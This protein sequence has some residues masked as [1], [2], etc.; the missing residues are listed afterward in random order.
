M[1]DLVYQYNIFRNENKSLIRK[2]L[3]STTSTGGAYLIPQHLEKVI[4]N[5]LPRLR[6]ELAMVVSKYDALKIHTF[7]RLTGLPDADTAMGEGGVTP[8][9]NSTYAQASVELK[10]VRHKGAVT[11]FL[12]DASKT[13]ID[14][15]AAEMENH[16][17]SHVN[18]L[19]TY[20]LHGNKEANAYTFTGWDRFISTNRFQEAYGGRVPTNLDDL[21]EMI[22]INMSKQ[23]A[24]HRK[25]FLLSP[26]MISKLSRLLTNVRLNQGLTGNGLTTVE[27]PGGWRLAAYR[28]IPLIPTSQTRP[29]ITMGTVTAGTTATG[30]TIADATHN[31]FRVS[32][33]TWDGESLASAEVDQATTGGNVSVITLSWTRVVGSFFYKIYYGATSNGEKLIKVIPART[34]DASGTPNGYVTGLTLTTI[35]ADSG[36]GGSISAAMA[37]DIPLVQGSAAQP[38]ENIYLID[39]DEFQGMG[40]LYYTNTAGSRFNGLVTIEPLAKTDDNLPFMVKSYAGLV[41]AFEA[42]CCVRRGLRCA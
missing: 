3:D 41:D 38:P 8:T 34:Y 13:Y 21:D 5:T 36:A 9:Y 37:N 10:V 22:D 23:G 39:L 4:T 20:M 40:G 30:G 31:Y 28:D 14:A 26:Y 19:T 24:A 2:A 25:G 18:N 33:V 6:P 7:N 12:Q 15:A 11:N 32:A 16:L 29:V 1:N 17:I 27:I 42:T 35:G